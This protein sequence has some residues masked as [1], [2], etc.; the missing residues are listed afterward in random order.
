M[1]VT[2]CCKSWTQKFRQLL[3]VTDTIIN[4]A[5]NW[6]RLELKR[7]RLQSLLRFQAPLCDWRR[8]WDQ[9]VHRLS[10]QKTTTD[11]HYFS[12]FK[13]NAKVCWALSLGK[14]QKN[15]C[16]SGKS[17]PVH[18]PCGLTGTYYELGSQ[19]W[20]TSSDASPI[21]LLKLWKLRVLQVQL[22]RL[23]KLFFSVPPN[24]SDIIAVFMKYFKKKL[25]SIRLLGS[26]SCLWDGIYLLNSS[27]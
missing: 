14:V 10:K 21:D 7:R 12:F 11:I 22:P 15:L 16:F 2:I 8:K 17:I 23:H 26:L 9:K 13:W 25:K 20:Y 3:P 1:E 19:C 6:L 18:I 4:T 24:P 27:K 5:D